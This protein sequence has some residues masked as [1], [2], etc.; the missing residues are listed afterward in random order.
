MISTEATVRAEVIKAIKGI[1]TSLGFDS[2]SKIYDYLKEYHPTE[3]E[4]S[5]LAARVGSKM[6]QRAW[7]V[8]VFPAS[9]EII[10]GANLRYSRLYEVTI[11]GYYSL[12]SGADLNL[13]IDHARKIRGA[14]KDLGLRFNGTVDRIDDISPFSVGIEDSDDGR[15][16]V[17]TITYSLVSDTIEY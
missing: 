16:L 6:T 17:A 8:Q 13:L 15:L 7:G 14:L 1:Y 3:N 4:G 5:Y 10:S 11:K 2:D 12:I 9:E